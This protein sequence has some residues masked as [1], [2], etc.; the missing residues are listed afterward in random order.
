MTGLSTMVQAPPGA[1]ADTLRRAERQRLARLVD[2]RGIAEMI[3][4]SLFRVQELDRLRRDAQ[5]VAGDPQAA[6]RARREARAYLRDRA[7]PCPALGRLWRAGAVWRWAYDTERVDAAGCPQRA[8]STGRTAGGPPAVPR[9]RASLAEQARRYDHIQ[10]D[11]V[12]AD[13][14]GLLLE[15]AYAWTLRTAKA[16]AARQAAARQVAAATGEPLEVCEKVMLQVARART[17]GQ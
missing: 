13:E 4:I 5:R 12:R 6:P 9:H 1:D 7:L 8:P 2:T 15:R 10:V 3:G 11:P 17:A 14:L 16:A